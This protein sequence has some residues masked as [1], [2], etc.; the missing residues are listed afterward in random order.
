MFYEPGSYSLQYKEALH[1]DLPLI[2]KERRD[3]YDDF[4]ALKLF[5]FPIFMADQTSDHIPWIAI[6][7]RFLTVTWVFK[8]FFP[9]CIAACQLCFTMYMINFNLLNV[10][11]YIYFYFILIICIR[12]NSLLYM[13]LYFINSF[14]TCILLDAVLIWSNF[15]CC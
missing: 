5:E 9:L 12:D 15:V 1:W 3:I 8:F 11:T 2:G 7:S 10:Y 14:V 6:C 13:D 4:S